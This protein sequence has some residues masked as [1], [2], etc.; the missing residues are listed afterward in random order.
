LPTPDALERSFIQIKS[1]VV[2]IDGKTGRDSVSVKEQYSLSW[3]ILS[4]TE[5]DSIIAI[6]S[7][8][9]PVDFLVNETNLVIP[10]VSVLV[11]MSSIEYS[12]P[13]SDYLGSMSISLEEVT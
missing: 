6:A 11:K 12:I 9:T 7:K 3:K 8:N 4:K 13:G 5:V 1:D 10:V 2:A